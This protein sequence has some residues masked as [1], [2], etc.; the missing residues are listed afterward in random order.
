MEREL[1]PSPSTSDP[2]SVGDARADD[3]TRRDD[4]RDLRSVKAPDSARTEYTR[5]M[6]AP[7]VQS[8]GSLTFWMRQPARWASSPGG[9]KFAPV[10]APGVRLTMQKNPDHT[11]EFFLEGALRRTTHFLVS[12]PSRIRPCGIHVA[13]T[14]KEPK[15]ELWLDGRMVGESYSSHVTH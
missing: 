10:N 7:H 6:V 1:P 2:R 12:L 9:I 4:S 3:R 15:V 14:W 13:L 11:L 8:Q 5:A